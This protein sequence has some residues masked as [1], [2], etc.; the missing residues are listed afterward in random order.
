[1]NEHGRWWNEAYVARLVGA[2]VG[3]AST[4]REIDPEADRVVDALIAERHEASALR[5]LR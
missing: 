2:T 1:M 4:V 3:R 5:P